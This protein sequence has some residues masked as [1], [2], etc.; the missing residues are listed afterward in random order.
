MANIPRVLALGVF[1]VHIENGLSVALG[2][3]LGGHLRRRRAGLRHG[4]DRLH[5]RGRRFH[6]RQPDPLP[7]KPWILGLAVLTALFFTALSSFARFVPA[8]FL[9]ATIFT[10]LW[11]GLISAY[12]KRAMTLSMTGVM[13]FVFAMGQRFPHA[14]RSPGA[15]GIVRA[16][17]P[18]LHRLR[19]IVRPAVRRPGAAA[20][21]GRSDA[22]PSPIT[23]APRRCSTIPTATGPARFA[24]LIDAHAAL[25]DRL[26]AARDSVF[27]RRN[28]RTQLKR[29]DTLIALL[30]AFESI[31]SSDAD[32]ELLR[33]PGRRDIKWR[34]NALVNLFA[35]EVDGF[36]LALRSRHSKIKPHRHEDECRE[37]VEAVRVEMKPPRKAM[38]WITPSSPPPASWRWPTPISPAWPPPW[39]AQPSRPSWPANWTWPHSARPCP[40]AHSVLLRQFSLNMPA[41]RYAVRLALAM[42]MGLAITMVLPRFAHANWVLLTIALIMRAN[43]SVTTQRRWDRVTGT[44]IGCALAVLLLNLLPPP[45]LL[46]VVVLSVGASHAYGGVKYRITAIGASVSSLLLLHFAAPL[47]ASAILRAHHRHADRGGAFLGIQLPAAQLE[48][49]NLPRL[50]RALIAADRSFADAALRLVHSR[51]GLSPVAQADH[52]RGGAIVGRD[53]AAGG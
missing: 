40:R 8:G 49:S 6:F 16:G 1:R 44:L 22:R 4:G 48:R 10:G 37:L 29:I 15:Y 45:A 32:F 31:L 39:T 34:M 46:G 21:A 36:T 11:T 9:A 38:R 5:R 24:R 14:R 47:V 3:G 50:V 23:C 20:A 51:P 25:T 28:S 43:F 13:S 17:G 2:V 12:G 27:A 53:P 42:A 35:D 33:R 26:Q 41:M 30:D 19:R 18:A 52:G 7:Q